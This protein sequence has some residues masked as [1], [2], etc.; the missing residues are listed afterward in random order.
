MS[1]PPEDIVDA[2]QVFH[3]LRYFS[4]V[5]F[6]VV[7]FNYLLTLPDEIEMIWA[8]RNANWKSKVVFF[9]NRYPP[10][11]VL[12]VIVY[13]FSGTSSELTTA[14][15]QTFLWV[16]GVAAVIVGALSHFVIIV[17][18]HRLWDGRKHIEQLLTAMF[19]VC[20]STASILGIIAVLRLQPQLSYLSF[21]HTCQFG[22]T[23]PK[24]ITGFL[25][26]LS[27]FDFSLIL[28]VI[29]NAMDRPRLAHVQIVSDLQKDGMGFFLAM[30]TL[31]FV[32]V[33][34]SIY[35]DTV[36]VVLAVTAVWGLCTLI[37]AH[38]HIRL[39]ALAQSRSNGSV[40]MWEDMD[41]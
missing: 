18:V 12:A 11:A 10:L 17:R 6:I 41:Y 20:I 26:V 40:V 30:F 8:N 7:A 23:K 37:N 3:G 2:I 28:F 5:P 36:E 22:P 25:A 32:D 13:I 4:V 21:L 34:V 15:C 14:V 24:E 19:V 27:F 33:L 29:F 31:R 9:A 39:E 35:R 38:L 16:Y 1:S